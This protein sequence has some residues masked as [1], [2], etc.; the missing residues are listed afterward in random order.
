M[1]NGEEGVVA[2]G[3]FPAHTLARKNSSQSK[4]N[5]TPSLEIVTFKLVFNG[6]EGVVAEGSHPIPHAGKKK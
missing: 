5:I 2:E 6:E 3:L 4:L 1:F